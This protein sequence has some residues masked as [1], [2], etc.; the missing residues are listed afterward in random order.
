[1]RLHLGCGN[2]Y[3]K[4]WVNV[5]SDK[6]VK[7]DIHRD[8]EKGLPF[9]DNTVKEVFSKYMV[10]HIK[11][12]VFLMN[13]IYRVCKNKARVHIIVPSG[14]GTGAFDWGHKSF[15][16]LRKF[17]YLS[18]KERKDYCGL[19]CNFIVKNVDER[20]E[21]SVESEKEVGALILDVVL[22]VVK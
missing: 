3:I 15:W 9:G 22:E 5:D 16:N 20:V 6:N 8:L 14:H 7:A 13:E 19:E 2:N 17:R 18:R 10:E 21:R 4:G 12:D 11:D 1:M